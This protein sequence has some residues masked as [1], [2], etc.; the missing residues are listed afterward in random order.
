MRSNIAR[1]SFSLILI[2]WVLALTI[3]V[4]LGLGWY[5][6][7]IPSTTQ[8]RSFLL[9]LH[10]SLGLTSGLLLSIQIFLRIVFKP[11]SFP[12]E[13]PQWQRLLAHALYALIY[14]SFTLILISGYLQAVFNATHLQFWGIPLP[15]WGVVD[16]TLAG[17]FEAVHGVTAVVL[18]GLIFV[19]VGVVGLNIFKYPGIAT[20]MLLGMQ[21]SPDSHGSEESPI[22]S[23]IA[24]S[25]ARNLRLFGWIAFWLQLVLALICGV[26]LEFATSG[27]A[28]SPA[29]A[30]G[31]G[32]AI[33]WGVVGFLLLWLAIPLAFYCTRAARKILARPD[34]YLNKIGVTS[35]RF[36][37]ASLLIGFLGVIIAFIGVALS[38]S[39]LIVKTV[40][41]PPGIAITDP[42]KIVRA[43]D[44]F[45][46]I[47]NFNLLV[48]H[49]VGVV[50]ALWLVLGVSSARL[51][52]RSASRP[53][54]PRAPSEAIRQFPTTQ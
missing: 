23:K 51:K 5:I 30:G 21:E 42:S 33:Y 29:A 22:L 54:L 8:S 18:V 35:L 2:H 46:L 9:D 4:M 40:S 44:V 3:F 37:L 17:F 49:F 38:I 26:L 36:L 20:R 50:V 25:L 13:F 43:L 15:V 7:Y 12:N 53:S 52:Y 24:Q 47:V 27:R 45:I 39:L 34:D 48:A 14:L 31:F 16:V 32:D 10:M 41:Q 19:H 6:Q 1:Y 11:P 28:F